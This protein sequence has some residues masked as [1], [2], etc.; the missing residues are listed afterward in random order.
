MIVKCITLRGFELYDTNYVEHDEPNLV[1]IRV[2][3]H[4]QVGSMK[5]LFLQG[6][7][8]SSNNWDY[9][10]IEVFDQ[11]HKIHEFTFQKS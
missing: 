1:K 9:F 11:G 4:N 10:R 6:Y 3:N 5:A 8:A 7:H 2:D